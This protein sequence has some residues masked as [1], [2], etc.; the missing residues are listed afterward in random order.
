MCTF[1]IDPSCDSRT[2]TPQLSDAFLWLSW[3]LLNQKSE[4]WQINSSSRYFHNPLLSVVEKEMF[5]ISASKFDAATAI[6]PYSWLTLI[7]MIDS[8]ISYNVIGKGGEWWH[9]GKATIKLVSYVHLKFHVSI[10]PHLI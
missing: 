5:A 3:R 1:I 2:W 10:H 7:L 4:R 6:V 8:G 9:V